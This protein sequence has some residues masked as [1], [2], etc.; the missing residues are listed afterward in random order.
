MFVKITIVL[1]WLKFSILLFDEEKGGGLR[2]LRWSNPSCFQVFVDERSAGRQLFGVQWVQLGYFQCERLLKVDGVVKVS[3]WG[4][5]VEGL[6]REYIGIF[7]VL[8]RERYFV[9]V[10][11]DG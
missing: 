2:G 7:R 5:S 9:F 3:S 6:F 4:E 1:D 10:D 11:G 8:L